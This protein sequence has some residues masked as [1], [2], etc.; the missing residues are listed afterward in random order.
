M[1]RNCDLDLFSCHQENH[2][3][4]YIPGGPHDHDR[5]LHVLVGEEKYRGPKYGKSFLNV[6]M[7]L[8]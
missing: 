5:G 8:I 3:A 7:D 6:P 1:H 2:A 4:T